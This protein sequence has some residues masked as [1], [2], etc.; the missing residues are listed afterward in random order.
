MVAVT[1][2]LAERA[3]PSRLPELPDAV[4]P[5]VA[6]LRQLTGLLESLDDQ[7]YALKP[8]G[9]VSSSIGGHVR[10]SLDHLDALLAGLDTGSI[11]YDRRQRGTDVER[12]R[13]AALSALHRLEQRLLSFSWPPEEQ[14][15]RMTVLLE[16]DAPAVEV[17]TS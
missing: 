5:L 15:L 17:V 13:N 8:V 14:S 16:P 3:V 2:G 11:D 10:H 1:C 12:C 7:Q 9:V 4:L 6:L